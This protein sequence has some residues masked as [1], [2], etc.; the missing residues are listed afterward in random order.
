MLLT[1][2]Q[3]AALIGERTGITRRAATGLL[4][5]GLAGTPR[6]T[7]ASLLYDRTRVVELTDRRL[8]GPR[9]SLPPE[10][11]GGVL[12]ARTTAV[13]EPIRAI[14]GPG[15]MSLITQALT[16]LLPPTGQGWYPLVVLMNHFVVAG[17][18]LLDVLPVPDDHPEV[19]RARAW[20]GRP[21]L[22]TLHTRPP[23]AWFTSAFAGRVLPAGAGN[24]YLLWGLPDPPGSTPR[25]N[26]PDAIC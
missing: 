15:R 8:V 4:N 19:E 24:R 20:P 13:T 22:W 3:A 25:T 9:T 17:A 5:A 18:E 16:R 21:R 11:A 10:C 6:R 2:R 7:S 26:P 12:L 1:Q 14:S 23:G